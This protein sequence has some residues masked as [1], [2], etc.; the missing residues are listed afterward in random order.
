VQYSGQRTTEIVDLMDLEGYLRKLALRI[1][2]PSIGN[3]TVHVNASWLIRVISKVDVLVALC[4][5]NHK[6]HSIVPA[7]VGI[8]PT[9]AAVVPYGSD[10][11]S[12]RLRLRLQES[13]SGVLCEILSSL[14]L[15]L[16]LS[17][18]T[19]PLCQLPP[20]PELE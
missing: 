7:R 8:L 12:S 20:P 13:S 4:L 6:S 18:Y 1:T 9:W 19:F 16:L 17:H 14:S 15:P 3:S 11:S 2:W 10:T 5:V